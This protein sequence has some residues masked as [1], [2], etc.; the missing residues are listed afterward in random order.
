MCLPGTHIVADRRQLVSNCIYDMHDCKI[1]FT[2]RGYAS[3]SNEQVI[4]DACMHGPMQL[5]N[6]L[7]FRKIHSPVQL[8][9]CIF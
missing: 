7:N 9:K 4:I 6:W 1:Y 5:L 3:Q 8:L 2:V